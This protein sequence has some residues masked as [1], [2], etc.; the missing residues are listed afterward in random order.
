MRAI[1]SRGTPLDPFRAAAA[2]E[3]ALDRDEIFDL[4]VRAAR[5]KLGYAAILT[6]HADGLRGWGEA[7]A[8]EQ[9]AS[10]AGRTGAATSSGFR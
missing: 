9:V 6:V 5:S 8:V 2:I 4:L 10:R 1:E 3:D 7:S